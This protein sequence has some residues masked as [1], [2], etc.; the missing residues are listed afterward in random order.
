MNRSQ[1]IAALA[2]RVDVPKAQI[3]EVVEQFEAQVTETVAD[4]D[5]VVLSGFV[6]FER[7]ERAAR[8]GRNPMTGEEIDIAAKTVVKVT[9]LK[10]FKDAVL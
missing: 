6:K 7:K 2:D 1:L 3:K 5:P 4:G 9:P 10:G 8:K